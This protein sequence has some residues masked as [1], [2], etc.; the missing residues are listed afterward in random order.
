MHT[1]TD[2]RTI[3]CAYFV[4]LFKIKFLGFFISSN[5]RVFYD[6]EIYF[7]VLVLYTFTRI[8]FQHTV[9]FPKA[10]PFLK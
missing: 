9:T 2:T 8:P 10:K 4:R 3:M 7:L 1:Q 5:T 6:L